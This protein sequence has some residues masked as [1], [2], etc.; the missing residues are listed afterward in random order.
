MGWGQLVLVT[1]PHVAEEVFQIL[2][3]HFGVEQRRLCARQVHFGLHPMQAVQNKD[4]HLVR[5]THKF[6]VSF[7]TKHKAYSVTRKN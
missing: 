7:S 1:V 3:V 6:E 5:H 2:R 4:H